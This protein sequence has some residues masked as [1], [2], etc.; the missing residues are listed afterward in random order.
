MKAE[1]LLVVVLGHAE[2]TLLSSQRAATPEALEQQGRWL[3]SLWHAQDLHELTWKDMAE[4][5]MAGVPPTGSVYDEC[6]ALCS[7]EEDDMSSEFCDFLAE[8]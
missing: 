6:V 1:L 5:L 3:F 8:L 4:M 7:D 2:R